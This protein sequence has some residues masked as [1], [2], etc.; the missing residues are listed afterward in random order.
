MKKSEHD[1]RKKNQT[2]NLKG[3]LKK[4][5]TEKQ[6]TTYIMLQIME[7]EVL[8]LLNITRPRVDQ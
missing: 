4:N 7:E 2:K 6:L 8:E 1:H 3:E 5:T